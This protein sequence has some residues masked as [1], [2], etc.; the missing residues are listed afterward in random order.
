MVDMQGT[1]QKECVPKTNKLCR[2]APNLFNRFAFTQNKLW[3]PLGETVFRVRLASCEVSAAEILL[4]LQL[5]AGHPNFQFII[6]LQRVEGP[7]ESVC[8]L[9]Y[10]KSCCW[11]TWTNASPTWDRKFSIQSVNTW[12]SRVNIKTSPLMSMCCMMVVQTP[13][14]KPSQCMSRTKW[15]GVTLGYHL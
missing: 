3:D 5:E 12:S 7:S 1:L 4:V 13:T 15:R 10:C 2:D 14:G 11:F 8:F 6:L 9:K